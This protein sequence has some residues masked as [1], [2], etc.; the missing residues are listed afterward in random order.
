MINYNA[1]GGHDQ[2]YL[3]ATDQEVGPHSV[4]IPLRP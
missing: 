2:N 1:I 4:M 3:I